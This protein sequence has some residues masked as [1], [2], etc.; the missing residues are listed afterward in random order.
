MKDLGIKNVK[1]AFIL[2]AVDAMING[3]A[4]SLNGTDV[5][6]KALLKEMIEK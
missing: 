3:D 1:D 6:K 2:G 4:T 5:F